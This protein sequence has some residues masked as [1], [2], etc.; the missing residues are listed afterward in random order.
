M[1]LW[2]ALVLVAV[3]QARLDHQ[4]SRV[5]QVD[6]GKLGYL[7]P[8]VTLAV[9]QGNHASLSLHHPVHHVHQ[10]HPDPRAHQALLE[11]KDLRDLLVNREQLDQS[12]L[13][14]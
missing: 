7:E 4:A 14:E 5:D 12:G 1:L 3:Y 2:Q 9:H 10:A 11:I 13:K 6:Q 8:L